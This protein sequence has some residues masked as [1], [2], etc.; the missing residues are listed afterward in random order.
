MPLPALPFNDR[1]ALGALVEKGFTTPDQY[2]LTLNALVTACNQKSCRDPVSNLGEETVLDALDRL[3]ALGLVSIVQTAGGRTDRWRHRFRDAFETS[4]IATAVLAELLL[5]GPQ[6]EGELRQGARRMVKVES[7]AELQQV[8]DELGARDEPLA[9]RLGPEG[10]RR[11]V[12]YAHT[13]YEPDELERIREA[14]ADR[15][16]DGAPDGAPDAPPARARS[17]RGGNGHARDGELDALK[18]RLE[19]LDARVRRLEQALGDAPDV[20]PDVRETAGDP[21]G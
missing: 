9:V 5:R 15:A 2:P 1:R 12:R 20:A 7:L 13:L 6:T 11:G 18:Q 16:P 4:G 17:G 14:E 19:A 10:R 8:L 21:E 3:R